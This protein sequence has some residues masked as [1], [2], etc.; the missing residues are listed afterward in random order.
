MPRNGWE[1]RVPRD[2]DRISIFGAP[3]MGKTT[4][5]GKSLARDVMD[6]GRLAYVFDPTGDMLRYLVHGSSVSDVVDPDLVRQVSGIDEALELG[7]TRKGLFAGMRKYR[8][9]VHVCRGAMKAGAEQFRAALNSDRTQ[10]WVLVADEAELVYKNEG[11]DREE[12][13]AGLKLVRNRRQRLYLAGQR[14]QWLSPLARSNTTHVCLFKADSKEFVEGGTREWG[15]AN[16]FQIVRELDKFEY[17]YRGPD[18]DPP[19][20][21][22]HAQEDPIPWQQ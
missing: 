17:V 5:L 21:V 13:I 10:G 18:S 22:F 14:P 3:G 1:M 11:I 7:A 19:Y 16:D 6:D 2:G 15:D 9:F 12:A 20:D 4:I 8:V